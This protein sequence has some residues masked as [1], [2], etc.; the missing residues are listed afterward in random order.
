MS[1][2]RP[3]ILP[4]LHHFTVGAVLGFPLALWLVGAFLYHLTGGNDDPAKYQLVMWVSVLV[5]LVIVCLALEARVWWRLWL[6]LLLAN[7]L[8]FA[9]NAWVAA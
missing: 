7:A 9:F 8:A 3:T 6:W 1:S 2:K 4:L 5:W